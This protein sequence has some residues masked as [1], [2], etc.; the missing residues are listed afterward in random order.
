MIAGLGGLLCD[1]WRVPPRPLVPLSWRRYVVAAIAVSTVVVIA[2]SVWLHHATTTAFDDW[3]LRQLYAHIGDTGRD[4]LLGL[5]SPFLSTVILIGVAVIAGLA[6]AWNVAALALIG[7]IVAL[8]MTEV[9]LKPLVDR[10]INHVVLPHDPYPGFGF[11]FPSGHETGLAS[12]AIVLALVL[13]RSPL[14]KRWRVTGWSVLAAWTVLGAVGLVR[15]FYHF[16][17]DTIGAIALSTAIVFGTA[18]LVDKYAV[19]FAQ[20]WTRRV[21]AQLT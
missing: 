20:W 19:S 15:G 2:L 3:A 8:I 14:P 5:S 4:V 10:M 13:R 17:T 18:L 1:H 12:A 6:R 9:V 21:A 7:P 16:A 11:A